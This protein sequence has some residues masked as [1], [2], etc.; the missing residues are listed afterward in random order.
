MS[1]MTTQR[2]AALSRALQFPPTA[3]AHADGRI[4]RARSKSEHGRQYTYRRRVTFCSEGF[5]N[6]VYKYILFITLRA[7]PRL[8]ESD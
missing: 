4:M 7:Y 6:D 1:A 5:V 8:F 2:T 3:V